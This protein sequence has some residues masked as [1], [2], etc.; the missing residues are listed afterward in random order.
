MQQRYVGSATLEELNRTIDATQSAQIAKLVHLEGLTVDGTNFNFATYS[1]VN[2]LKEV[3]RA[4]I[5]IEVEDPATIPS[6]IAATLPALLIFD[7]EIFVSNERK[8]YLGFGRF[9]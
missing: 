4:I 1:F 6:T 7:Q 8:R 9:T 3:P 2:R 5:F